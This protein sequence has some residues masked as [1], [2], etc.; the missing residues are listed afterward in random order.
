MTQEEIN[1]IVQQVLNSLLTSGKTISQLTAAQTVGDSDCFELSGGRKVPFS[2]LAG[3]IIDRVGTIESVTVVDYDGR[4]EIVT[5]SYTASTGT[6]KVKQS[7]RT[8]KSITL[9]TA[10]TS[11][12]GLMSAADKTSLANTVNKVIS[13]FTAAALPS[14]VGVT[15]T[16][17]DGTSK[18]ATIP[19]AT[20]TAA[21]IMT[22]ADKLKLESA[23]G[24]ADDL[25]GKVGAAGGIATLDGNG[26]LPSSQ[27]PAH[28]LTD[29]AVLNKANLSESGFLSPE[30]WPVQMLY[31]VDSVDTSDSEPG[32]VIFVRRSQGSVNVAMLYYINGEGGTVSLGAPNPG[33]IYCHKSTGLLYKWDPE[34]SKFVRIGDDPNDRIGMLEYRQSYF[35]TAVKRA[36]V[37]AASFSS[38]QTNIAAIDS[39]V[40]RVICNFSGCYS[41][42]DIQKYVCKDEN[43]IFSL[44]TDNVN[45][46]I[47]GITVTVGGVDVSSQCGF[48]YNANTREYGVEIEVPFTGDVEITATASL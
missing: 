8:Q 46:N 6:I 30:E 21:G 36:I 22:A 5:L 1:A 9:S 38:A 19:A 20:S 31:N 42:T 39:T 26:R 32:D 3:L 34:E 27:L 18:S 40:H 41:T 24:T 7:G 15:V 45:A 29:A 35:E 44:L 16:F 23:K 33:V 28:V 37:N 12:P 25:N 4:D 13:A 11:R 10:T 43:L 48:E 14:T 2:T 17:A 47:N